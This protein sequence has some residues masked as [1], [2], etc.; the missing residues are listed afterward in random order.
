MGSFGPRTGFLLNSPTFSFTIGLLEVRKPGQ[1][2]RSWNAGF[3]A[4]I[5]WTRWLP[6]KNVCWT[7]DSISVQ[8]T[9]FLLCRTM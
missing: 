9:L 4:G 1:L 8:E 6:A 7:N 2:R 3:G 5:F